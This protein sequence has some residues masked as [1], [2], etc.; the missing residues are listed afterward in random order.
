[1]PMKKISRWVGAVSVLGLGISL[2][3]A[4]VALA[5][6]VDV[7]EDVTI[8]LP[9]DGTSYTLTSDSLFDSFT[10]NSASISFTMSG[11]HRVVLKSSARTLLGNTLNT[12]TQCSAS[13]SSVL[14]ELPTGSASQTVTITPSGSCGG[15]GGGGG[16][17]GGGSSTV[18]PSVPST[19]TTGSTNQQTLSSL[20]GQLAALQQQIASVGGGA[21]A[22]FTRDLSLGSTGDDVKALQK[23][24]A[25][26][27]SIYPEGTV[28]GYFGSLTES[29]VRRFQAKHGLPQVGRVGPQTRAKLGEVSGASTAPVAPAVV[30]TPA[31][32]GA[33]SFTRALNLGDQNDDVRMLQQILARDSEIYPEAIV[34][35]YFGNLTAAAVKRFQEKYGIATAGNPGYGTVGPKTRAKLNELGQTP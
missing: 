1:M 22:G 29:A 6:D 28:S 10:V 24:L 9:G 17:G 12:N 8:T 5:A 35:G 18:T 23:L 4:T 25:S 34:S 19:A 13:E 11:G 14:L 32:P 20:Q 2:V 16:G 27:P 26:D 21:S 3:T 31:V 7:T 30:S 15:V 33:A